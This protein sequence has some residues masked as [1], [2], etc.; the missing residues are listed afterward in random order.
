MAT[1]IA[2]LHATADAAAA[3]SLMP[4]LERRGFAF[5][6]PS[7]PEVRVLVVLWSQA[8]AR[9][10]LERSL[11]EVPPPLLVLALDDA[12]APL[13]AP[14]LPSDRSTLE[15][16]GPGRYVSRLMDMLRN[17]SG[18][19]PPFDLLRPR[20]PV[21]P[22]GSETLSGDPFAVFGTPPAVAP[23]TPEVALRDEPTA[24]Q[25]PVSRLPDAS[26]P[27]ELHAD[28][29][30][31]S[32][33]AAESTA[34]ASNEPV[35]LAA[36]APRRC[37]TGSAFVAA[38]AAYAPAARATA[39]EQLAS[40]GEPDDRRVTD[41]D[42]N[43]WRLGAPVTVRLCAADAM[44]EPAEHRFA[45]GGRSHL[46]AFTV[47]AQPGMGGVLMLQFEVFVAGVPV[48]HLPLRVQVQVG[49]AGDDDM[50]E[51]SQQ[52]QGRVPRTAFAS[53]ASDDAGLVAQRLSTLVHWAPGLDIFQDCLDLAPR[54]A[55]K[56]QLERQI[57]ARDVFLLFWSRSAA[58][59][60]WV[61]WELEKAFLHK[62]SDAILPMP[63]EDPAIAP[64][65]LELSGR[66]LR[67]RFLIAGYALAR[68]QEE[69]RRDK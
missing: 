50:G 67:D 48:A 2:V 63:L 30:L 10:G 37:A 24:S 17:L 3:W 4:L 59:S 64:P 57:A 44:V 31:E 36:S 15:S 65:P 14:V 20:A 22:D 23:P 28:D 54:E 47:T 1:T 56:P 26:D 39:L 46:S 40:L 8:A 61:R 18:D 49:A 42:A 38:L 11:P 62:D 16:D 12:I 33:S 9:E 13:V 21:A 51:A 68:I 5:A 55:F 52:A 45:W 58:A 19:M 60:R 29:E 41:V 35:L 6:T 25:A 53:Y 34:H 43:H 69:A 66:H 27:F 32:A 7:A